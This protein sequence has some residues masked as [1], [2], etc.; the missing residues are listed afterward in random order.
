MFMITRARSSI[1]LTASEREELVSSASV[2]AAWQAVCQ[3]LNAQVLVFGAGVAGA[4]L[5]SACAVIQ[6][7]VQPWMA[8][9]LPCAPGVSYAQSAAPIAAGIA[10]WS[11]WPYICLPLSSAP[12]VDTVTIGAVVS[13][14][15][16]PAPRPAR[17]RR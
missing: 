2:E 12:P 9:T 16:C 6:A 14:V 3:L 8:E 1:A 11:R 17:V 5:G 15:A 7:L 4:G 10:A 13:P